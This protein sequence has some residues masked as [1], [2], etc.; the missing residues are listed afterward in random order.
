[1]SWLKKKDCHAHF[2]PV[3]IDNGASRYCLKEDTRLE[4]PVE[5]G[6]RP[7]AK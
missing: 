6:K 2:E 5:V 3:K 1:M 4:G 7:I